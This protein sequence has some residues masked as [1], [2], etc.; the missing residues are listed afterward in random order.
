VIK[1]IL[2]ISAILNSVLIMVLV[3]IIPFFLYSSIVINCVLMWYIQNILNTSNELNED[4]ID[5]FTELENYS[6]HLDQI[7]EMETFYGD[8]NLQNLISHTRSIANNIID[9]Q[10]KY[11]EDIE[12]LEEETEEEITDEEITDEERSQD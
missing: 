5:L 10:R 4:V 9:I 1:I 3:G 8:Q 2:A 12:I 6:N 11:D 7:H